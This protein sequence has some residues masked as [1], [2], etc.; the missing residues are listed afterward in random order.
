MANRPQETLN[1]KKGYGEN[2]KKLRESRK[3]T[4]TELA[5]QTGYTNRIIYRGEIDD[6]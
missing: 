1:F 6:I 3:L 4:Q 5:E 2:F